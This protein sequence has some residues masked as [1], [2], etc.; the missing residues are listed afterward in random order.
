MNLVNTSRKYDLRGYDFFFFFGESFILHIKT[1][2]VMMGYTH[3]LCISLWI[4]H[5]FE[6]LKQTETGNKDGP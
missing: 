2:H 4:A 6:H 1:K 5:P 3:L